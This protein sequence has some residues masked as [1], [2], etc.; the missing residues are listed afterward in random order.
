MGDE[1]VEAR[2][3]ALVGGVDVAGAAA[4]PSKKRRELDKA[5]TGGWAVL[6]LPPPTPEEP[7]GFSADSRKVL[8]APPR[9]VWV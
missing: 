4:A 2:G 9:P 5:A 1:L 8:P 6:L 3:G 7:A